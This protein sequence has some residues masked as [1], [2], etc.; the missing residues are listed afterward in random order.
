[1]QLSQFVGRLVDNIDF[2][3][4]KYYDVA[5]GDYTTVNNTFYE[6][7]IYKGTSVQELMRMGVRGNMLV[8]GKPSSVQDTWNPQTF[9]DGA[10]L[11][12][13]MTSLYS[14]AGWYAGYAC[15]DL[16]NDFSG[17]FLQTVTKGLITLC[18]DSALCM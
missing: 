3:V 9:I 18:D 7:T 4:M 17:A 15:N 16:S 5:A 2:F 6:A 12:D 14:K 13:S 10:T 1:M 8:V 11:A